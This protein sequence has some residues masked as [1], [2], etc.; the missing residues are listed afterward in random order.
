MADNKIEQRLNEL[1]AAEEA[2]QEKIRQ[3]RTSRRQIEIAENDEDRA[4][5]ALI[6]ELYGNTD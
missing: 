5:G 3:S 6:D 1:K 4:H 2:T